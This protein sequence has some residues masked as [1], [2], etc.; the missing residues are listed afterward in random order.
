MSPLLFF[1]GTIPESL[2]KLTKLTYLDLSRNKLSGEF[3]FTSYIICKTD[4]KTI[5]MLFN[6][7]SEVS[8]R[9]I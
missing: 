2:G 8:K 6:V 7:Y 1:L 9:N 4:G 5:F 3:I